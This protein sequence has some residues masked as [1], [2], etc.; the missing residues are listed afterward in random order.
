MG[1]VFKDFP[2][3]LEELGIEPVH[4]IH[5][6][7][8]QGEEMPFYAEAGVGRVTLVE[9]L[10]VLAAGLRDRFPEATVVTAAC[11]RVE[12]T[13]TLSV[14]TRT[15]LSTL[16]EPT[17]DDKVLRTIEVPVKRLMDIQGDANIAVIDAQGLEIEVL[18]AAHMDRFDLVIVE[19]C[20]VD[21]RT[22][23]APHDATVAFME[24]MGFRPVNTW[25]RDYQ[26]IARW[27][28]GQITGRRGYVN[29]VAFIKEG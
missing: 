2:A 11:G 28:R 10:P 14:M 13:A 24:D 1:S 9:P 22:I 27:G 25:S 26:W 8:H 18:R 23:A 21:D 15:N 3:L 29:D 4:L 7:A 20:T 12:G 16:V 19:T 5:V 17:G 6:G